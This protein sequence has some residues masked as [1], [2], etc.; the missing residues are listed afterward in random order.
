MKDIKLGWGPQC[1]AQ[2]KHSVNTALIYYFPLHRTTVLPLLTYFIASGRSLNYSV[3]GLWLVISI[4]FCIQWHSEKIASCWI[5]KFW[6]EIFSMMTSRWRNKPVNQIQFS[7]LGFKE[8]PVQKRGWVE[9]ACWSGTGSLLQEAG[10][11]PW[12]DDLEI[13]NVGSA[14]T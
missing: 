10:E 6:V 11:G 2:R 13:A 3:L 5:Y 4:G 12:G 8:S 9:I 14:R 1:L 7:E